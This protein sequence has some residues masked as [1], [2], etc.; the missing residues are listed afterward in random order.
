MSERLREDQ[1]NTL[2]NALKRT[3]VH[4][5]DTLI[6]DGVIGR[7]TIAAIINFLQYVRDHDQVNI[8]ITALMG[9]CPKSLAAPL[10]TDGT[11]GENTRTAL[12]WILASVRPTAIE[13][14]H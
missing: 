7:N 8:V 3:G 5:A 6:A 14:D 2:I 11:V 13:P 12:A 10:V 4:N 1:A 9:I